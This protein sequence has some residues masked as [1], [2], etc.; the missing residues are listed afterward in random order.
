VSRGFK[1]NHEDVMPRRHH[2]GRISCGNGFGLIHYGL[3][4]YDCGMKTVSIQLPDALA[5]RLEELTREG[6]IGGPEQVIVEALRRYLESHRPEL[7]ASQ[8]KADVE[9]G[10]HGED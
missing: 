3:A 10:L 1:C 7:I 5:K 4:T 2:E 9:W 8:I 6:W